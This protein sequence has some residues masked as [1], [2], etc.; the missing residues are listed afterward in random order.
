MPKED[1][2][3][4]P[5]TSLHKDVNNELVP[6]SPSSPFPT[7]NL[8][9]VPETFSKTTIN[10]V[11]QNIAKGQLNKINMFPRIGNEHAES[12][13]EIQG[14]VSNGNILGQIF[15]AS[16]D[17]INTM[18]LTL[19]SAAGVVVD[20]FESYADS[21]ALQAVWAATG[22]L[23][24]LETTTVKNGAQAMSLPTTNVAD[25]WS[26]AAAPTDYTDYTG[27]F[28]AYFSHAFAAQQ[29]S[30]FIGDGTNTKSFTV[31]QEG[32]GVW[33]PCEVN[34]KAMTE[35]QA[36]TTNVSAITEIGYRVVV[37][38]LGGTVIIDDLASVPPPGDIEVKLWNMGDTLPESGVTSIDDGTQYTKIGL[39][40]S[41]SY[42]LALK[43]GKRLYHL[44][45]FTAGV[46]KTIPSTEF[47]IPNN[48]GFSL[49][50]KFLLF[51]DWNSC[52]L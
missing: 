34:E 5:V 7:T 44:D 9:G 39:A 18:L 50:I 48:P 36:G 14:V 23:A 35:D 16:K 31:I 51:I 42:T 11:N 27:T 25:E 22:A 33:C 32:A 10:T 4:N 20:N 1:D 3:L 38:K 8:F 30:V 26:R 12:S 13:R 45:D 6:S 19:E 46:D 41:A 15:K 28:F 2:V 29:V 21:A 47:L 49:L 24:T 43:G 52:Y 17:N 40:E 37:K